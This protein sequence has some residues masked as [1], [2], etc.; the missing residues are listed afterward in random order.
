[1]L[2]ALLVIPATAFA[3]VMDKEPTIEQIW[4]R[5]ALFAGIGFLLCRLFGWLW[6][7]T[8]LYSSALVESVTDDHVGPAILSEAGLGYVIQAWAAFALASIIQ[9]IG[10]WLYFRARKRRLTAL[11]HNALE[12]VHPPRGGVD[13]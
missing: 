6:P 2:V 1:M 4:M 13:G 9:A 7:L 11:N 8:M 3:E 12:A 10:A 5:A